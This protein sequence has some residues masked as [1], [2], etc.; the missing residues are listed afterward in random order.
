[1]DDVEAHLGVLELRE[2]GDDRLDGAVDVA[3]DDEVEVGDLPALHLLEQVLERRRARALCRALLA[4]Q[5]LAP[6]VRE[7]ACGPLVI[8][9]TRQLARGRRLVEAEDL[10]RL[11]RSGLLELLA[12]VVVERAHLA[13][14]VAGDERVAD[15]QRA[16]LDEHRRDGTTADI[17]T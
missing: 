7:I 15:L 10:D 9:D 11:A 8:D 17:E 13:P 6:P 2:L 3:L 1:M 12:L 14:R 16:A 4:A 5:A